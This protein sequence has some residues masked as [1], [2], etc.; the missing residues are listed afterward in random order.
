MM[1]NCLKAGPCLL[2]IRKRVASIRKSASFNL[3]MPDTTG[4]LAAGGNKEE[5]KSKMML[6]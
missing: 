1:G 5:K 2:Q 6:R 4:H 3:I